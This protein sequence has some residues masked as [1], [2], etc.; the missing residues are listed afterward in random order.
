MTHYRLLD[1]DFLVNLIR[2]LSL[3]KDYDYSINTKIEQICEGC[4]YEFI[5]TN[6]VENEVN[7]IIK[8]QNPSG[9]DRFFESKK[10]DAL[11]IKKELFKTV[12]FVD[13]R[14]N[15]LMSIYKVTG[16]K[17]LGERSLAILLSSKYAGSVNA[18]GDS[19][20]IVSNNTRDVISYL[21]E[22]KKL[23]SKISQLN[24]SS[25][26]IQNYDFYY[27][28]FDR[29]GFDQSFRFYYYFVSNIDARI[30]DKNKINKLLYNETTYS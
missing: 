10:N 23:N 16:P 18:S 21:N 1:A 17:N 4:H 28:L 12:R 6:F 26:V 13:M 27:D 22:I 9:H 29:L 14:K 20:K 25:M 30:C 15:S 7:E 3:I 5:S 8:M 11:K 24:S 19:A 2:T